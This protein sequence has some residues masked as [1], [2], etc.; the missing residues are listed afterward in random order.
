[1]IKYI[2]LY[3]GR[4]KRGFLYTKLINNIEYEFRRSYIGDI[5]IESVEEIKT[6]MYICDVGEVYAIYDSHTF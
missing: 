3:T 5:T 1:M 4:C 6:P 2:D